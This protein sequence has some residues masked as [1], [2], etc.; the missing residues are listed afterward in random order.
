M[1]DLEPR[2]AQVF[3]ASRA[4]PMRSDVTR[5]L[6]DLEETEALLLLPNVEAHIDKAKRLALSIARRGSGL[7]PHQA[8]MLLSAIE[9]RQRAEPDAGSRIQSALSDLRAALGAPLK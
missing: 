5:L 9:D 3:A 7:V 6:E 8:M 2:A 1:S 4:V